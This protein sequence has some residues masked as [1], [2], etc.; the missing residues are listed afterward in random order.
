MERKP[1]RIG[2]A[3]RFEKWNSFISN[4]IL[5]TVLQYTAICM[6]CIRSISFGNITAA[7]SFIKLYFFTVLGLLFRILLPP[8]HRK[9]LLCILGEM[10]EEYGNLPRVGLNPTKFRIFSA[11]NSIHKARVKAHNSNRAA[12]NATRSY[13]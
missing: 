4:R 1:F 10:V 13:R 8:K 11:K 7:F 6:Q 12:Q 2:M 9:Q 3:I 5:D